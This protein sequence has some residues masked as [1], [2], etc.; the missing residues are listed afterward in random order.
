M[1]AAAAP[2]GPPSFMKA[3]QQDL[4]PLTTLIDPSGINIPAPQPPPSLQSDSSPRGQKR[5]SDSATDE[6]DHVT[7]KRIKNTEAAR[8]SRA[9]K[10]A[11][12]QSLENEVCRLERD[13]ANMSSEL[14]KMKAERD[15]SLRRESDLK[16]RVE[17]LENQLFFERK[18]RTTGFGTT[19]HMTA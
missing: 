17:Q 6:E 7:L 3:D 12:L 11:R 2:I 5:S 8:R 14:H 9:R 18:A 15:S 10:V 16:R 19:V 4:V 1:A 13:K